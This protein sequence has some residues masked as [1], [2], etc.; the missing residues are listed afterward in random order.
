VGA[1]AIGPGEQGGAGGKVESA[2]ATLTAS[3]RDN[4]DANVRGQTTPPLAAPAYFFIIGIA[5][6]VFSA[7]LFGI[8]WLRS[9]L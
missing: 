8:G 3:L 1:T 6:F 2:S 4:K 9:R 7:M 5:L